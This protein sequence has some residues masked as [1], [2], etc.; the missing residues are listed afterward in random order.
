MRPGAAVVPAA[1]PVA[2]LPVA[3]LAVAALAVAAVAAL[4]VAPPATAATPRAGDWEASGPHGARA[5]FQISSGSGRAISDL[6]VQAPISCAN[7]FGTPLPVDVEVISESITLARNGSF[8]GGSIGKSA[9]G[10]AVSGRTRGGAIELIYRHTTRA[11][12]PYDGTKEVC[13]TGKL[14][15]TARP[16]H[17]RSVRDGIWEGTTA[18]QEPVQLS[19]DAGGRALTSPR[20]LGPGGSQFY[21][22]DIGDSNS[23]DACGYQISYPLLLS[24]NGSFSNASTRLGDEA[25]VSATFSSKRSFSGRF[26]NLEEGCSPQSWSA[27]WYSAKP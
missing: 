23:N 20:A 25:E 8:A 19:V 27:S 14:H 6:V 7:A 18:E 24:P 12:N 15:L 26:T 4:A 5:S 16:G 10:T 22:F 17:R 13:D 3:G 2:A 9:G 11:A 1:L 21:A